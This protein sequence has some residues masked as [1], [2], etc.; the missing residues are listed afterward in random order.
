MYSDQALT[1]IAAALFATGVFVE[2]FDANPHIR[3]AIELGLSYVLIG[4]F[5]FGL[6]ILG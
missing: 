5:L 1:L 6:E 3:S 4:A 2:S